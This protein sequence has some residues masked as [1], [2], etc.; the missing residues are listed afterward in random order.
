MAVD[1][2]VGQVGLDGGLA[3]TCIDRRG[4]AQLEAPVRPSGFHA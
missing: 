3:V 1:R 4:V 2:S